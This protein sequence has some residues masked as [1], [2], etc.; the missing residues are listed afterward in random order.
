MQFRFHAA[1][2]LHP[3][4]VGVGIAVESIGVGVELD[5]LKL[6]QDDTF[7]HLLHILVLIGK[8]DVRPYLCAGVA[9]PH[10]VDVA[11]VDKGVGGAVGAL[12]VVH[13]GIEGVGETVFKHPCQIRTVFKQ[14]LDFL[15]LFLYGLGAEQPL[16]H[17]GPFRYI[18]GVYSNRFNVLLSKF[19]LDGRSLGRRSRSRERQPAGYS[20]RL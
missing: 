7:H 20:C 8:L 1:V 15:D 16:F 9:S 2:I 6:A 11:R 18:E 5:V 17:L 13:G 4:A 12:F 3:F 19:L 14:F 10:G